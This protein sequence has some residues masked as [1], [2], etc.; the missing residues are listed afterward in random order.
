MRI[1]E[2]IRNN[3]SALRNFSFFAIRLPP[4]AICFF[5]FRLSQFLLVFAKKSWAGTLNVPTFITQGLPLQGFFNSEI[6][7]PNSE[8]LIGGLPLR[9]W[10]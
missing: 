9:G 10:L 4:F 5:A 3:Q 7:I 2:L 6:R 8:F 1:A